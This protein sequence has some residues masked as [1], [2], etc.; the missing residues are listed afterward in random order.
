MPAGGLLFIR[1]LFTRRNN[2]MKANVR[3]SSGSFTPSHT[4][5]QMWHSPLIT[6]TYRRSL[7]CDGPA[8]KAKT[9]VVRNG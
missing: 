3:E 1:P 6:C 8:E 9:S 4:W 7:T 2:F 5:Y